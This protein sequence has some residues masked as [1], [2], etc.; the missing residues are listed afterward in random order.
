VDI[1]DSDVPAVNEPSLVDHRVAM[2][3]N[4]SSWSYEHMYTNGQPSAQVA[5]FIDYVARD[6]ALLRQLKFM[7]AR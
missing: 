1:G 2:V 5:G 4:Y 7:P 3:K 6:T